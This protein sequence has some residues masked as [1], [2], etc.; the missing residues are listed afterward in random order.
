MT[1]SNIQQRQLGSDWELQGRIDMGSTVYPVWFRWPGPEC[2]TP[3]DVFLLAG[4]IPAMTSGGELRI[5]GTVSQRLMNAVPAIQNF[6]LKLPRNLRP[7]EVVPDA[8][9]AW[10]ADSLPDGKACTF[11]GGVDSFYS[12]LH[13]LPEL[14]HLIFIYGYDIPLAN[15]DLRHRV[16]SALRHA[17]IK[18]G[19]PLIEVETNL[20]DFSDHY[21]DWE[22]LFG[23]AVAAVGV[24]LAGIN[25]TLFLPSS[26][27]QGHLIEC[28]S[29]PDLDPLFSTERLEVIH[30]AGEVSR[31]KKIAAISQNAV[32]METL[33]VC[34]ENRNSAYNCGH[35]EKCVRTLV[36]LRIAGAVE[37]CATFNQPIDIIERLHKIHF[38]HLVQPLWFENLSVAL[39]QKDDRE[40]IKALKKAVRRSFPRE[41]FQWLWKYYT[42]GHALTRTL[43]ISHNS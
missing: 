22:L 8:V 13:H 29:H 21:L 30:D 26:F 31:I 37:R 39:S 4:L 17:A 6:F 9:Y 3:G 19:K 12:T 33:R 18:L 5:K 40:L 25:R 16:S 41:Y 32:A 14:R 34:W 10:P 42:Q 38:H 11:T 43:G 23:A 27:F 1:I 24:L 15:A 7:V 28:G 2:P 36:A 35:C 20:R